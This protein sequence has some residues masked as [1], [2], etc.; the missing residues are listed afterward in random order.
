MSSRYQLPIDERFVP[1]PVRARSDGWTVARQRGFIR[2]L[3]DG[4]SIH[5]AAAHVNMSVRGAYRLHERKH[6]ASFCR[7][8]RIAMALAEPV[9]VRTDPIHW[10]KLHRWRG[11]VVHR[12]ERWNETKVC[13][14]LARR[15]PS[16]IERV[17]A[18]LAAL[19]GEA[20][21]DATARRQ[22]A[23]CLPP[24]RA[25]SYTGALRRRE[26]SGNFVTF[27]QRVPVGRFSVQ[28]A[29]ARFPP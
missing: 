3:R 29:R 20:A 24:V 4:L 19:E 9:P 22:L 6:A 13:R 8:W 23:Q 1:V 27:R 15:T 18:G 26:R 28:P 12:E 16:T 17:A 14:L 10:I 25:K 21:A 2:A 7:A 11:R 5:A